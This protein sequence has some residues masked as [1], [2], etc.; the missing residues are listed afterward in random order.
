MASAGAAYV[1]SKLW[2]PGTLGAAATFP[3]L[4][5]LLKEWL[6]R[7]TYAVARAVPVRGVVRSAEAPAQPSEPS[8]A[9]APS[10]PA[11]PP[12]PAT[13]P[14]EVRERVP[15]HGEVAGSSQPVARRAWRMAVI[16]GLLGFLV[17]AVIVS[18]PE[19]VAGQS[20]A[21]GGRQTTFFGGED[22]SATR[23][24]ETEID[25][26]DETMP[27]PP[28]APP[29]GAVPVPPAQTTTVPPPAPPAPPAVPPASPQP[30][31]PAPP[32]PAPPAP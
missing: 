6:A 14:E 8:E 4:I 16:T 20:A 13:A 26:E 19:F 11:A 5:A 27:A 2:A 1:T 32:A 7:P 21:G 18:V 15:Q 24:D 25:N 10:Q 28:E 22:R 9:F 31:P 17:A 12:Q 23:D 3:V 29:P 30:E